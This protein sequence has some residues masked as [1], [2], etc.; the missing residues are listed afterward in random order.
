M[1]FSPQYFLASV[2][3]FSPTQSIR[4]YKQHVY[5]FDSFSSL[6]F[7]CQL[8]YVCKS[9]AST[10]TPSTKAKN[11]SLCLQKSL[12]PKACF[13][14][15]TKF[16]FIFKIYFQTEKG[17]CIPNL[18]HKTQQRKW[19]SKQAVPSRSSPDTH[20][21]GPTQRHREL[22][23]SQHGQVLVLYDGSAVRS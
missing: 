11:S 18:V 8:H 21:M 5:K 17:S 10:G 22:Y 7:Y 6:N 9:K 15:N 13:G 20:S 16:S 12:F 3:T 19:C 14:E 23:L 2:A 1:P 4:N